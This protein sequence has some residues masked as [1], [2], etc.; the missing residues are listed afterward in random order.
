MPD[1]SLPVTTS[2]GA[3]DT[4]P[5]N[6]DAEQ[7][8][9]GAILFDNEVYNRISGYLKAEH[10]YD[11]V[12][13]AI[14]HAASSLIDSG[15]LASP[16]TLSSYLAGDPTV[17][18]EGGKDYLVE[19]ATNV[20]TTT[21]APEYARVV[22]DLSVQRGLIGLGQEIVE[23]ARVADV[24]DDP[25][26]QIEEAERA[27]YGLAETG[28]FGGGFKTFKSALAQAI[29]TAAA[30]KDREGG[31]AGTA[32][33][34]IDLDRR[35]GGLHPSDLLILAGRPS[36]GKTSLATNL[37]VNVARAFRTE[38]GADGLTRVSA[39]GVVGFFSLEM[40]AEQLAMRII[41]EVSG[42]SSDKIRRGDVSHDEFQRVHDAAEELQQIPLHIDDTGGISI[43]QLAA[44]ARRLKRQHGLN[45]IVVDYL[46]LVTG[47]GRTDGRVQE[48]SQISQGLKALAKELD[49]PLIALSQLS[50][51]VEARDDKRPQ[52]ADLRE[53]G[54]IEQDA[55]I[56]MFVYREEY[57]L[58][59]TEPREGSAEYATWLTNMEEA[60][61]LAE[62]IVGKQRHGP[63]GTVKLSFDETLTKFSNLAEPQRYSAGGGEF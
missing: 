27:L 21:S 12:H 29:D 1:G 13:R 40:S 26:R 17:E 23:R 32:T 5:Y 7:N 31:L 58:R 54:S 3:P 36:M 61:G 41:A 49:V 2:Q 20:P 16:V 60:H 15:R 52:L 63:I 11:P 46:Q 53:S 10:F 56:V 55:D 24:D 19:I 59:R 42:V 33:G 22:F 25:Q 35:L 44:R 9:L 50:R 30:A 38:T 4:L 45:L 18:A 57:Y 6:I 34:F 28:R 51:Q 14:F 37:A 48:V 43:A 62:V 47:S 8:V 39:G